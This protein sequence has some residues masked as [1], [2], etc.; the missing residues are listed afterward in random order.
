MEDKLK[1]VTQNRYTDVGQATVTGFVNNL[2]CKLEPTVEE[3]NRTIT[4]VSSENTPFHAVHPNVARR[5]NAVLTPTDVAVTL[6]PRQEQ[7]TRQH[8]NA[9]S[10]LRTKK[11]K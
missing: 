11:H 5:R 9:G 1:W 10:M 2:S 8:A 6:G 4:A 7:R 3:L